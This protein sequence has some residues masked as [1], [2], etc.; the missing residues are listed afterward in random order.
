MFGKKICKKPI[1]LKI[2]IFPFDYSTTI[3]V[4]CENLNSIH[5]PRR[6]QSPKDRMKIMCNYF[7][8]LCFVGKKND[9]Q[10]ICRVCV[11]SV[12]FAASLVKETIVRHKKTPCVFPALSSAAHVNKKIMNL[13]ALFI[14]LEGGDVFH[15]WDSNVAF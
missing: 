2:N 12:N 7:N 6:G 4:Q 5:V 13:I 14:L 10:K 8:T 1:C 11:Y 9:R 15:Q 3:K